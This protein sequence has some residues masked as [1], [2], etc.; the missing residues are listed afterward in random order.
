LAQTAKE[1]PMAMLIPTY[2]VIG[3]T[4][5]FGCWTVYSAGIAQ[6]AAKSLLGVSQM[7]GVQ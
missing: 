2:V 1:A 3:S 4:I 5:V 6:A 7:G